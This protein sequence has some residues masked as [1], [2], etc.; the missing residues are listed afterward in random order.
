M[1]VSIITSVL[2]NE[3]LIKQ[4]IESVLTQT[5]VEIAEVLN[6]HCPEVTLKKLEQYKQSP[7]IV[8]FT[9]TIKP[10]HIR[11]AGRHSAIYCDY[12]N[13]YQGTSSYLRMPLH[14]VVARLFFRMTKSIIHHK[15]IFPIARVIYRM[16]LKPIR[17]KMQKFIK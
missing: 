6:Q 2:N 14:F 4:A 8:H 16:T 17:Q 10:W 9:G 11:Y 1:K 5:Y 7:Y 15:Q 3:C 12:L 13:Q